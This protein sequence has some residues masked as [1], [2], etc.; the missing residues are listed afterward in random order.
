MRS[1]ALLTSTFTVFASL[2]FAPAARAESPADA[3][4]P[5]DPAQTVMK[6]R[7]HL[8]FTGGLAYATARHPELLDSSFLAPSLGIHAGYSV[9]PK[10]MVGFELTTIEQYVTREG[11]GDRFAPATGL[12]P[13]AGC[14]KCAPPAEG[15]FL[16]RVTAVF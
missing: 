14:S 15:G 13:Q 1:L 11:P 6:H 5:T 16:G 4:A 12:Q 10:W 3:V 9:T 2:A 8:G 7:Y